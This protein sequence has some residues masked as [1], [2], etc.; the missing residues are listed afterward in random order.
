[1]KSKRTNPILGFLLGFMLLITSIFTTVALPIQASA[2]ESEQTLTVETI[3]ENMTFI[4][5]SKGENEKYGK[6]IF[7][8]FYIPD[9]V[10]DTSFEYGVIVFPKFFAERYGITGNYVEEYTA[11]GMQDALSVIVVDN[12]MNTT[13]GKL[14]KCG[15]FAIPDGGVGT[16]LSFIFYSKDSSGN[17][18]YATPRHAAYATLLVENY[19][20]EQIA[21]M[22]GQ[23][24]KTENSFK[25]IVAKIEE[26]VDAFWKYIIIIG[27]TVVGVWG[28][29]IGVRITVAQKKETQINARSM[30][31]SFV[32]GIIVVF[33]IAVAMPLLIKGLSSWIAW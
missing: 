10:Y 7:S 24:L 5:F 16:E 19:S 27:A 9:T 11:I 15:I 14:L 2:E 8:C 17:I 18:A 6:H 31:K 25:K 28:I 1:M 26:L 33:V 23:T 20:N 3:V 12:P 13:D 29:V 30:L 4:T 22:V 21:L 32:I